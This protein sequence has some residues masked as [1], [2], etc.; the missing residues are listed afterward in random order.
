VIYFDSF[1]NLSPK[2]LMQY[3][4]NGVTKI[5]CPT[6]RA[7]V[8]NCVCSFSEWSM[9]VNLKPNSMLFISVF[10]AR[11]SVMSLTYANREEQPP[12]YNLLSNIDLS[13]DDYELDLMNFETYNTI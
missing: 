1:G 4:G 8:N 13:D 11:F 2:E 6:F 7:S 3:F 12:R 5:E 9:C 10:V